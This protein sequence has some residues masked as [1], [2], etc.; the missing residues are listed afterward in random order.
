MVCSPLYIHFADTRE[1][2]HAW[3]D[4]TPLSAGGAEYALHRARLLR[5]ARTLPFDRGRTPVV[6]ATTKGDI[7][8]LTGWIRSPAAAAPTLGDEVAA[9]A[10]E[11][12]LTAP[13]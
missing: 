10:R 8:G 6:L 12:D 5:A 2:F 3:R 13:A 7:D 11:L 9:L 1:I 4:S